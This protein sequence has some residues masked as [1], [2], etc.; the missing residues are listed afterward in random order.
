[1]AYAAATRAICGD[2]SVGFVLGDYRAQAAFM[3]EPL[4][5]CRKIGV[6]WAYG[7]EAPQDEGIDL[8]RVNGT[9]YV[10]GA[11]TPRDT[12]LVSAVD[13][14]ATRGAKTAAVIRYDRASTVQCSSIDDDLARND[15]ALVTPDVVLYDSSE[16]SLQLALTAI[17]RVD[18]A[19]D[20]LFVCTR[21]SLTDEAIADIRAAPLNVK[22]LHF[23]PLLELDAYDTATRALLEGVS[24]VVEGS[25]ATTATADAA[26]FGSAKHFADTYLD[27]WSDSLPDRLVNIGT[28]LDLVREALRHATSLEP[29]ALQRAMLA[30]DNKFMNGDIRFSAHGSNIADT[31]I[32]LQ[33]QNG[34]SMVVGPSQYAIKPLQYPEARYVAPPTPSPTADKSVVYTSVIVILVITLLLLIVSVVVVIVMRRRRVAAQVSSL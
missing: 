2:A 29:V 28:M 3:F 5:A 24:S 16:A 33:V 1:L 15:I 14:L 19:P 34:Q 11:A 6:S 31:G 30:I 22:A 27:D 21:T 12:R 32:L 23:T 26:L 4:A 9:S 25:A 8:K 17:A 7:T 13:L 18:S 20:V 10:F